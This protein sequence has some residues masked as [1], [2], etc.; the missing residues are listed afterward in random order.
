MSLL[1]ASSVFASVKKVAADRG[2]KQTFAYA[3]Q[4]TYRAQASAHPEGALESLTEP[5]RFH[6]RAFFCEKGR[7][8]P[9]SLANIKR[10]LQSH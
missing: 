9:S 4:P 2:L 10:Q 5:G 1:K 3:T 7:T 8:R 6:G